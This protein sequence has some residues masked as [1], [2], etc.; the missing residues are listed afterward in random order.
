MGIPTRPVLLLAMLLGN[1]STRAGDPPKAAE[2][3][4]VALVDG[5]FQTTRAT[6]G[7]A[8]ALVFCSAECPISNGYSPTL[9]ELAKAFPTDRV[10]IVGVYVDP[11]LTDDAIAEHAKEYALAYPVATDR[12][13]RLARTLGVTVT[14]EVVV[15][16]EQDQVRYLGR[17]DDQYADRRKANANPATSEMKDAIAAVLAGKPIVNPKVAAVGCPLPE[18]AG[19]GR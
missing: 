2:A 11:D 4:G 10:A 9:N 6:K 7:G 13:G 12:S 16:D 5:N 17:I 15:L 19:D 8:V 3:R 14:P 18:V 1:Q